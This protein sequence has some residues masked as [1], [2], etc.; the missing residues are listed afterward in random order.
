MDNHCTGYVFML[1]MDH[2]AFLLPSV[3]WA[4]SYFLGSS[5]FIITNCFP[6]GSV[7]VMPGS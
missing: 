1:F 5:G 2:D 3:A 4:W 6:V 7:G